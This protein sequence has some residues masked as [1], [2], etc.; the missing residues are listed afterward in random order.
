MDFIDCL[1]THGDAPALLFPGTSPISYAELD[2][3]VAAAASGLGAGK[4]LVLV[5]AEPSEHGV[6][7][8]LAALRGRHA[9]ALLPPGDR[10][11]TEEF[12]LEFAPDVVCRRVDGRWRT[13]VS[14]GARDR[15]HPDLALLL[16]TSGSTGTSRFVRLSATA[17]AA[18]ASSVAEFLGLTRDDR[19][20][21]ILPFHYSYGLSVLHSHLAAGGSIHFARS[22]AGDP[23]FAGEMREAR[24]TNIAGVP[25]SY[26]LMNMAGFRRAELPALRF[27]AIAG[28]RIEPDLAEI[29]R[30]HL[31][32]DGKRLFLM[33]GQTEATARIAYVPPE[34]LAGNLDCIG[35]AIPGGSLRLLDEDGL[36]VERPGEVGELAYRGPNVMMGYAESRAD[37][38]KGHEIDELR[39]G[40]LA[41]CD[42]CG[43]FRIVG[44]RKRFSKIA[45]LRINHAAVEH[46]LAAEGISA[47][48][49]GD[50]RRLVAAI[51]SRH[52]EADARRVVIA[53]TGL[54]P[55]HVVV[56]SVETLPRLASGKIDY[57]AVK[58]LR[59]A[60][61]PKRNES[62]VEA[63]RRAFYPRRVAPSDSFGTLGGNS[64]LYV[65]LSLE[66][67]RTLGRTPDGW[68]S[69]SVSELARLSRN[70]GRSAV[71]SDIIL[72]AVAILLVVVH[73]ATLWPIPGG[74][75]M[76]VMLVG[77]G[78]ARFQAASLIAGRP[79]RMLR[80]LAQNL[81]VYLPILAGFAL[82]RGEIP[83][84]SVFLVGNLGLAD[85]SR[86][87][88]YLYWFVEA[89]AQIV[90]I[91]A[92]LFAWK[93]VRHW[94]EAEPFGF[95]LLLLFATVAAKQAAPLVWNV[96]P[97][98]IFTVTDVLY[99]AVLG[100]CVHFARSGRAR[101]GLLII[102]A[103]LFPLL[104]YMG[105]NWT[106]SWVK[107]SMLLAATAILLYLPR[108]RLP[109]S[110]VQILLPVA[111]ASYHIYL[112]HR[113]LP[114]WLLPQPDPAI[115]QPLLAVIAVT[116]GVAVGMAAFALQKAALGMF[117]RR[118]AE[119]DRSTQL[120]GA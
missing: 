116:S 18:N 72:R 78:I 109:R 54:T 23:A 32:A 40:D 69:M 118:R 49:A 67:E 104:A 3:R 2:R 35:I 36:S 101:L 70:D 65:Q 7:A 42:A 52:S 87:L 39:T 6:I 20:A 64:L 99:L 119:P 29:F 83:W 94:A 46:A 47:A 86:M 77:F 88:P 61:E 56:Q 12:E 66:L 82:V 114:D 41:T 13:V 19:A 106:G 58:E 120:Q 97:A 25:Y 38:G 55:L 9:V 75:A 96:G 10:N 30:Q 95:G 92:G 24:C 22:G 71:D 84:A 79:G 31:S 45:G 90:L 51:T 27:M 37:V 108:L 91:W 57:A 8:Y 5:E 28:G 11:T 112:F 43:F 26:E 89:Y 73:H 76:L 113:I 81:C 50:D 15:L 33:Y 21:L 105:G 44:R 85:P 63:F 110:L 53:A 14:T 111:A 103:L 98:Q 74:A 100:W 115:V 62:V 102:A 59:A 4:K 34:S 107:F 60:E 1:A 16:R 93:P 17:V 68:E 80:S 48:V 117:A